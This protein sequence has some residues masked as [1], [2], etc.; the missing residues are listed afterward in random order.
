ME[1]ITQ[2]M[3]TC[4]KPAEYMG[5]E[6]NSVHKDWESVDFHAVLAF[7]DRYE[8]GTS[9]LGV[10]ILYSILNSNANYLCERVFAPGVD[11]EQLLL[12]NNQPLTSLESKRPLKEFD[13]IGFSIPYEMLYSNVL[14]MLHLAQIP[15]RAADRGEEYPLIGTGGSACYN[16]E[17]IADFIDFMVLGDGEEVLPKIAEI[18]RNGKKES[19]TKFEICEELAKLQGVYIPS[20]YKVEYDAAGKF[21]SIE[22]LK[23]E[24]PKYIEKLTISSLDR[25]PVPT[26]APVPYVE[27]VHDRIMMEISRGCTRGCRFCQAGM[28][29]RPVRERSLDEI[30]KF[31]DKAVSDSGYEEVSLM[32]L[33]CMDHTQIGAIVSGL[34]DRY[35]DK[36]IEISLPSL[37]IDS[38]SVALAEAVEKF[39]KTTL[40]LAPEVGSEKMRKI[41]NKGI[42]EEEIL[43]VVKEIKDAGWSSI[44]LYFMTGLP[45]ETD[46]DLVAIK[47]LVWKILKA[48]GLKL[49]ISFSSFIPKP[50]TPFQWEQFLPQEELK[51]RQFKLKTLLN[52][53]H[54]KVT[55]KFHNSD[56]SF[57]EA[58]FSRGD[59]KLSKVLERA[60][61][62][63]CKFD[64][65][66]EF[67]KLDRWL[68]AFSEAGIDPNSYTKARAIDSILPWQHLYT[69]QF[70]D[71]LLL[72]RERAFRGDFTEDCRNVC[73]DCSVCTG[74]L[75]P[76]L[77]PQ[78]DFTVPKLEKEIGYA[79]PSVGLVRVKYA[80]NEKI[81]LIGHLDLMR[82]WQR[83]L[84][85]SGIPVAYTAGFHPRM[86]MS[87]GPAIPLG[88]T[89]ES[90]WLDFEL[91]EQV[92]LK[93]LKEILQKKA[94]D[95]IEILELCELPVQSKGV[96]E[97]ITGAI[98]HLTPEK[99]DREE[100]QKIIDQ[101]SALESIII[102]RKKKRFDIRPFI[103]ELYIE[104]DIIELK[105][106]IS[107]SGTV[108]ASEII[109]LFKNYGYDCEI[110]KV[111]KKESIFS[112]DPF[113]KE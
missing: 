84:R 91:R 69:P 37:R 29:Y 99:L 96:A 18:I 40:T 71:Y 108:K 9:G 28:I 85:R 113:S 49:T 62:L 87:L 75:N 17:P 10:K 45:N 105:T 30:L 13:L 19:K 88:I 35:K 1:I 54:G 74:E 27:T 16:G 46:E 32:S 80:K 86:K 100:A 12:E 76:L 101:I 67:F 72:E 22:P 25:S 5:T 109:E 77:Q 31:V 2:K 48:S 59:R 102:D 58:I 39:R 24:Y 51:E 42:T 70:H 57:L 34:L 89:S 61:A 107:N 66:T 95:G 36:Y 60:H 11:Y 92:D 50:H 14:N 111:E 15:F 98:Y 3:G 44:K 103:K 43:N 65:W 23:P 81:R 93:S 20:F 4:A 41:V 79:A 104:H 6:Y 8:I 78:L 7:P 73:N 55:S 97:I 21:Q 47:D 110:W 64:S 26:D 90:E 52:M 106:V 94:G 38:F 56:L 68:Q 83:I 112:S 63:G 33:S 53:R 82:T